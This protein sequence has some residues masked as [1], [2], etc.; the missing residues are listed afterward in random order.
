MSALDKHQMKFF[1][2]ILRIQ[3]KKPVEI[4]DITSQISQLVQES[5]INKGIAIV[6][7]PHTTTALIINE[8]EPGL[9]KDIEGAVKDIVPW[10]K[11]YAHNAIDNNAPSHIVGSFLGNSLNLIISKGNLELGT[12]QSIFFVELDGPRSRKVLVRIVG[13]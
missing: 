12:W 9:I 7:S 11:N 3:T 10:G 8:N 4:V 5:K 6:Y 2:K 13:E 1:D